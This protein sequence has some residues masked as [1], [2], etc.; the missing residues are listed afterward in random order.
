MKFNLNP[1]CNISVGG[2]KEKKK[3]KG[4]INWILYC[5]CNGTSEFNVQLKSPACSY[6]CLQGWVWRRFMLPKK[7]TYSPF[8]SLTCAQSLPGAIKPSV[9]L[10]GKFSL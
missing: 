1:I 6:Y 5:E 3:P 9:T 8:L 7:K 2:T 10:E 4:C